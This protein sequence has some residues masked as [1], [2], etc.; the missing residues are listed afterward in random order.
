MPCTSTWP[1]F[2]RGTIGESQGLPQGQRRALD[3]TFLGSGNAFAG[4]GCW[5]GFLANERVLFDAPPTTLYGLKRA[6]VDL[7]Q[8]D[9]V[10]LS[11]FHGDH[12][13]WAAVP[14]AG[15]P[16]SGRRQRQ[17]SP[18]RPRPD[19]RRPARRG[20][21]GGTGQPSCLPTADWHRQRLPAEVR[22][23]RAGAGARSKGSVW[24]PRA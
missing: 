8:I 22:R 24:E 14:A 13:F 19:H 17:R 3:L 20:R 10:L 12:F 7:N 2:A 21:H 4:A 11:H 23:D 6:G 5:S 9:V 1:P 16:L 15:V 18:P